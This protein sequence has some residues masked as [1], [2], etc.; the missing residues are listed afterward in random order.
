MNCQSLIMLLYFQVRNTE[1]AV[2]IEEM[3]NVQNIPSRT[4]VD[5]TPSARYMKEHLRILTTS[6]I[7]V[8]GR[9]YKNGAVRECVC[10]R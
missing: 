9:G 2:K 1:H 5:Q 6:V 3:L 10:A 7:T 4:Q 8:I